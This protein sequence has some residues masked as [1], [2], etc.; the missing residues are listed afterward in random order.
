[1]TPS[2]PIRQRN[3]ASDLV[4]LFEFSNVINSSIDLNFILST[5]LLTV[6]GKMLV[7]KGL[8]MLKREE[9]QYEVVAAKGIP[10]NLLGTS[11]TIG[12][13]QRALRILKKKQP[14][15]EYHGMLNDRALVLSAPIIAQG[16][17]VGMLALGEKIGRKKYAASDQ[18][19]IKSLIN[20]SAS[21]IEKA[22]ML[23]QLKNA[24][25]SLDRKVQ[26]LN[27]LFELSKEF[28]LV[29]DAQKVLR[30]LTF[31]LLGQIG[32]NRYA[33]CLL[34]DGVMK[35]MMS[36]I[37]E[38]P[39]VHKSIRLMSELQNP[40]LTQEMRKNEK[41]AVGAAQ[42]EGVGVRAVVP[43][44]VQNATKGLILLGE[45][46]HGG[47]YGKADLEFVYSLGNLAIISVENA[48][49]FRETLEKQR[50]EDELKIAREIQQGLL[51]QQLPEIDGF[52]IGAINVSS[53]QVG[54]DYYDFVK[55]SENEYVVA[56]GDVSG[57]GAPAAL[58]MANV[59]AALR[60]LAP[61]DYSLPE[62]TARINDLT[63]MNTTGDKFITFFWGV[64]DCVTKQLRYV[65]AGHNPPFLVRANGAVERLTSGGLILGVM[66]TVT[67]YEES[68]VTLSRGDML[69]MYTDGVSE[70]MNDKGEDFTEER[71]E[72]VVREVSGQNASEIIR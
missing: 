7:S 40:M 5:V 13:P 3:P 61:M 9:E 64:I 15:D 33:I 67:P 4:P 72:K 71:L 59:Q 70:A 63:F 51:P 37:E 22:V 6:M 48:R 18:E 35:I 26:E 55:R 58:L 30:L 24:N 56:I 50:L 1:M 60:A 49:L 8:V 54:G 21:A 19:L 57:K 68:V 43:M 34:E 14:R 52:D 62:A 23:E 42:L 17:V 16:Q 20:L 32:V 11:I 10:A 45:R 41:Y 66:K 25:R 69:F 28:N 46:L 38:L 29:L 53:K 65:N 31:S 36:R 2:R 47:P 12:K 27:T 44:Q 39:E